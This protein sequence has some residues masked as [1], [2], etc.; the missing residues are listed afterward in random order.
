MLFAIGVGVVAAVVALIISAILQKATE[1]LRFDGRNLRPLKE[2]E[3]A[4]LLLCRVVLWCLFIA[5]ALLYGIFVQTEGLDERLTQASAVLVIQLLS[6]AIL[7]SGIKYLFFRRNLKLLEKR[8]RN[9]SF[10]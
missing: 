9:R 3:K 6:C 1:N 2:H 4:I 10:G 8:R 5:P 7:G